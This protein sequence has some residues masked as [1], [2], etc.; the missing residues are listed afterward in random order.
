MRNFKIC[1]LLFLTMGIFATSCKK[2]DEAT[3]EELLT[4]E[5]GWRLDALNSNSEEIG[6]AFV[7]LFIQLF[8]PEQQTAANEALIR[9]SFD[10]DIGDLDACEQDDVLFFNTDGTI[11]ENSGSVKC[12]ASEPDES[13]GGNWT[14]SAD[15]QSLTIVDDFGDTFTYEITSISSSRMELSVRE[16]LAD[17]FEEEDLEEVQNLEGYDEFINLD[18]IITLVLRAN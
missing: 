1:L 2:D 5:G 11:T 8:P 12:S 4:A 17:A 15:G 18:I 16:S 6:D 13:S 7:A 3:R 9:E 14:L 10:L